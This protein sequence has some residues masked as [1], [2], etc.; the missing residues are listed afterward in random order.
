[1]NYSE[2]APGQQQTHI[3]TTSIQDLKNKI[4]KVSKKVNQHRIFVRQNFSSKRCSQIEKTYENLFAAW[5][6]VANKPKLR[7]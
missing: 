1:M 2:R 7:D 3:M 5:G 6:Q 4:L